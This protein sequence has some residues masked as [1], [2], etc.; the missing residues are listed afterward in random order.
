MH[1]AGVATPR[2]RC[3]IAAAALGSVPVQ[4][5]QHDTE[6]SALPAARDAG[7]SGYIG[8]D[9]GGMIKIK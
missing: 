6:L 8:S 9:L 3:R 1:E 2:Y 5:P 7:C 4:W